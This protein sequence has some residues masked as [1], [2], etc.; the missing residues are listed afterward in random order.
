[1]KI[2]ETIHAR[3]RYYLVFEGT[4]ILG[5]FETLCEAQRFIDEIND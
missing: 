3:K 4:D 1:M 5:K 2:L